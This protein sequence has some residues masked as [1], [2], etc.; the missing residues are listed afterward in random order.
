[1]PTVAPTVF[2]PILITDTFKNCDIIP[3]REDIIFMID[4]HEMT[5]EDL[6]YLQ[7]LFEETILQSVAVDAR[8]GFIV[9]AE[10]PVEV[11]I[12]Y[13]NN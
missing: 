11:F 9:Y 10:S 2:C 13:C 12:Y 1:M 3:N 5:D 7:G 4:T 6:N 8:V